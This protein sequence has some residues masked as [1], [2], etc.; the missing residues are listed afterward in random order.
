MGRRLRSATDDRGASHVRSRALC[1]L[2]E[3]SIAI[4]PVVVDQIH[5]QTVVCA[6]VSQRAIVDVR[7]P[8]LPVAIEGRLVTAV[9]VADVVVVR[10]RGRAL[11]VAASAVHPAVVHQTIIDVDQGGRRRKQP[12]RLA[13]HLEHRGCALVRVVRHRGGVPDICGVQHNLSVSRHTTLGV[14]SAGDL[15]V[16]DL[17]GVSAADRDALGGIGNLLGPILLFESASEAAGQGDGAGARDFS[18][19]GEASGA[20]VHG[21]LRVRQ[22]GLLH[23]AVLNVRG[24]ATLHRLARAEGAR[25]GPTVGALPAELGSLRNIPGRPVQSVALQT[26]VG[27]RRR[28]SHQLGRCVGKRSSHLPIGSGRSSTADHRAAGRRLG[29]LPGCSASCLDILIAAGNRI[30]GV[31]LHAHI[32]GNISV[33][34]VSR[35]HL[36]RGL[37]AVRRSHVLQNTAHNHDV[38]GSAS[39]GRDRSSPTEHR[40]TRHRRGQLTSNLAG[41]C[42]CPV[43][44]GHAVNRIPKLALELHRVGEI[45][46]SRGVAGV[47]FVGRGPAV[48]GDARGGTG[49]RGPRIHQTVAKLLASQL[50][51]ANF[52]SRDTLDMAVG[53]RRSVAPAANLSGVGDRG[54]G[55]VAD[56]G[57]Q[58]V[59]IMHL[60]DR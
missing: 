11:Q 31:P 55:T 36:S 24:H 9:A 37:R 40:K 5:T 47:R 25:E 16:G 4:A 38:F 27:N 3:A 59:A 35:A 28:V 14:G 52:V 34:Q 12:V 6:S 46:I 32:L 26:L 30:G 39:L 43:A 50:V 8:L 44:L 1:H 57:G 29:E 20:G 42:E 49:P 51:L 7:A 41:L 10:L 18:V 56:L 48:L 45:H 22:A 17:L 33:V 23:A 21:L 13:G 58:V 2:V 60:M 53:V 54:R 19:V 15:G